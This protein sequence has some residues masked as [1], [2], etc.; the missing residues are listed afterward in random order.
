VVRGKGF[1]I[2]VVVLL[3][4]VYLVLSKMAAMR[5]DPAMAIPAPEERPPF[6]VDFTLPDVRGHLVRL[7]DLRG[8]PVLINIW[9]TWCY[10]CREEM[11]SMNALYKDYGVKGLAMVAIAMDAGG[12]P[13][14]AP[15][16]QAYGFT[17]PVLLDPQNMVGTQL[18]V[19]GIPTSYLLD[20]RGR[21]TDFVVGARDWN[22]PQIRHRIEQLL[23]EEGGGTTP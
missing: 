21:V 6:R 23:M 15:F 2:A 3:V 4:V 10:P 16:L 9:A 13:V 1:R 8:R 20:K 11:P 17:F 7:V 5:R 19:P 12:K 18:Q 14:V 22:S